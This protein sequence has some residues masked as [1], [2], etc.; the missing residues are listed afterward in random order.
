MVR[1]CVCVWGG[2]GGCACM[3]VWVCACVRGCGCAC[4]SVCIHAIGMLQQYIWRLQLVNHRSKTIITIANLISTQGGS[5]P[6][7]HAYNGL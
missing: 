7:Y 2:G 4:V 5:L 1:S 3:F 6:K